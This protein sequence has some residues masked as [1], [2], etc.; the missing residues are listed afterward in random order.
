[1]EELKFQPQFP[2]QEL[3]VPIPPKKPFIIKIIAGLIVLIIFGVGIALYTRAWDP[4]WNPFRPEPE[5]VIEKMSGKMAEVKILHSEGKIEAI[6]KE[7][8]KEIFAFSI[9]FSGDSDNTD[10]KNLKS[11]FSFKL[12]LKG[13]GEEFSIEG[14][15]KTIGKIS[16]YKLTK[17]T[18]PEKEIPEEMAMINLVITFLK[19]KWFR[20]DPESILN[21]L[22]K[23][24][25]GMGEPL[26]PE[27]EEQFRKQVQFQE[28]FSKKAEELLKGRK[29]YLIKKEFP[30]VKIQN[31]KAYH[32]LV[33]LNREEIK[34]LI[35]E[36]MESLGTFLGQPM[37]K[38]E[39]KEFKGEFGQ[40][41]DKMGEITGEIWIGKKDLYLYKVRGEK[42]IDMS[43]LELGGK[44]KAIVKLD[45]NFAK[46]NQPIEIKAPEESISIEEILDA[47]L[48][49]F[50]G[51]M[52]EARSRAR[53]ARRMADL[54]QIQTAMEI[55]YSERNR[56]LS[57][58]NMPKSIGDYL[59]SLSTDPGNGP[60]PDYR[61][62]SNLKDPQ[63]H[64]LYTCLESGKF[65]AVSHKGSKELDNPPTNLDCW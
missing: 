41:L 38:E 62:I 10:P 11:T 35:P 59:P 20:V 19:D 29:L 55:Y 7:D 34:R 39:I 15:T 12:V 25:E 3:G 54:R 18:F 45:I 4:L 63:K 27:I 52:G 48:T 47:I 46:F 22:K 42:E 44:G 49:P 26:P 56:Y 24:T 16:Y 17:L 1:M 50:L 51:V 14:E 31:K 61:W 40:F 28:E 23:M 60:C 64:C 9:S 37:G 6:G 13:E 43:K 5:E 36:M 32:Y 2:S 53:D 8:E 57:S 21:W 65:F 33:S 58:A 30:D